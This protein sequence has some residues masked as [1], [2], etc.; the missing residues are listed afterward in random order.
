[1]GTKLLVYL[2]MIGHVSAGALRACVKVADCCDLSSTGTL[3]CVK[4]LETCVSNAF[5][6]V[7]ERFTIVDYFL[8]FW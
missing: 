4:S 8:L 2:G 3:T 7:S 6:P 5:A 1:V